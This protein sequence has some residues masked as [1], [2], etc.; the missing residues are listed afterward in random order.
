MTLLASH[1]SRIQRRLQAEGDAA[2]SFSHGVNIGLNREAFIREFLTENISEYWGVG[3]GEIIHKDSSPEE[4]RPQID[5]V[6]HNKKYPKLSLATNIDLFFIETV[7]SFIEIKSR[8]KKDDLRKTATTTR[9]IKNLA[10]FSPQRFN[11]VGMVKNPR[12]YSFVFAYEGPKR[13]ETVLKWLKELSAEDDYGL[14]PLKDTEPGGR[15]FF[16]HRFVDGVFVLGRGFVTLDALPFQ[17]RVKQAIDKGLDVPPQSVWVYGK[18]QELLV[19]W[20]LINQIN[21]FLL[22][23]EEDLNRHIG[24]VLMF[25]DT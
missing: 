17:S 14:E 24:E 22:W 19:L 5:V 12:P 20:A 11:P 6:V 3:T 10:E 8:L 1:F 16:D 15:F 21:A 25:I 13:I 7:S 4:S 9:H 18:E 2:K 23:G